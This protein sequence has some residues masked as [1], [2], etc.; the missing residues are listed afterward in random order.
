MVKTFFWI[1]ITSIVYTYMGY[2][3]IV[4]LLA[5]LSRRRVTKAPVTPRVSVVIACHNEEKN[6]EGRIENI[7]A[8]DYPE[9]LLEVIVVSDGSTDLTVEAARR[10]VSSRA[11]VFSYRDRMGKATAL[12]IGVEIAS[13]EIVVFADARQRFDRL[14]LREIVANFNDDKVGAVSGEL[15]LNGHAGAGVGEGVGLYWRYEKWIRKNESRC[16]SVIGATGAIYAIRREMW[17]PLPPMTILDDVYT[18]M[19]IALAGRR[20]IFEEKALAYDETSET[21]SR[22]FSRKVR[23]LTG[24]Y[25]LCQLMPRL[26]FP[27]SSLIFQFHSHKLM[28]LLVPIFFLLLLAANLAIVAEPTRSLFY[29][30]T[31]V[32]QL[33][34]YCSVLAGGYLLR[35]NRKARL[36][37]FAYVFSVMN[38]AALVSLFYFVLGKRNVWA[39]SE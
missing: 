8:L 23:T 35:K 7:L 31:L 36:L 37:N 20:V 33:A 24:N 1:S 9:E 13:G 26:L 32:A 2:P 17:Q 34:F 27:T 25:Q 11:R 10:A 12:N 38:A 28:R 39:R 29:E 22:E 3:A 30:A 14:A 21:A 5:R 18:P 6:I 16:S 4:W 19:R 15:I